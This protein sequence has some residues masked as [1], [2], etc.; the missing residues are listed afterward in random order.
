MRILFTKHLRANAFQ[1]Q[2][3]NSRIQFTLALSPVHTTL[4]ELY[5]IFA[6]NTEEPTYFTDDLHNFIAE[7]A[8]YEDWR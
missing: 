3:G 5:Y 7:L 4:P 2:M 1:M 6:Q 8:C